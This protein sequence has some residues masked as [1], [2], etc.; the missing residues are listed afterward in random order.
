MIYSQNRQNDNEH[1]NASQSN[2][3][4]KVNKRLIL[5]NHPEYITDYL[6]C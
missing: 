5:I 6:T 3:N 1:F 2:D 4:Y